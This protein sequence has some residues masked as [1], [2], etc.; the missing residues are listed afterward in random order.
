MEFI[1]QIWKSFLKQRNIYKDAI[2]PQEYFKLWEE[3]IQDP[4]EFAGSLK[5]NVVDYV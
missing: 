2:S 5:N 4:A 1:F 3:V